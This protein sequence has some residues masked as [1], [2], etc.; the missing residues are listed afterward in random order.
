VTLSDLDLEAQLRGLRARADEVPPAP[1]DLAERVRNRHRALR[2]RELGLAA[3]AIAAVLVVVGVPVLDST[4]S[5]DGERTST[6][7]PSSAQRQ[8]TLAELPTRGSLAGDQDWLRGVRQLSWRT[9]ADQLGLPAGA[10]ELPDPPVD[11]RT[12]AY[13]GDVP[14]GRVALVVSQ[15]GSPSHAWFTGPTGA[16]PAEMTLAMLPG[17]SLLRQPLALVTT[18]DTVSGDATLVVAS[19]PGDEVDRLTS[20]TVSASGVTTEHWTPVAMADGAGVVALGRPGVLQAGPD[21]RLR[22]PGRLTAPFQPDVALFDGQERIAPPRVEVADPRGLRGSVTEEDLQ[23]AVDVVTGFYVARAEDLAPTLLAGGPV[24]GDPGRSTVLVGFTFPSGATAA[25]LVTV[26]GPSVEIIAGTGWSSS[27]VM[28]DAAPA[29]TPLL[30]QVFAVPAPNSLTVSGPASGVLAEVQGPDGRPVAQF[31]L[32]AGAG[33][34]S[35]AVALSGATVRI[36]DAGGAVVAE[37]PI[38]DIV[39]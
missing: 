3:A 32:T 21:L 31:P 39:G 38:S 25:S 1:A 27:A 8:P 14:G 6:A 9:L 4:F 30:D 29:G 37:S 15:A 24:P 5:A 12:V 23:R 34:A 20:R 33:S 10:P 18:T 19:W 17:Q 7:A 11:T 28:T 35:L 22:R 13:A 36:L 26:W 2:R 16:D